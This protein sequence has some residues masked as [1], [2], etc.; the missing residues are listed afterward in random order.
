MVRCAWKLRFYPTPEQER[1]L[2][3]WFGCSQFVWNSTFENQREAYDR[4]GSV[5]VG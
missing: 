4:R 1:A 3:P 5:Q 2:V